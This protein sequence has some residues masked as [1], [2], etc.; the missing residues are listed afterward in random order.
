MVVRWYPK[1]FSRQV[2]VPVEVDILSLARFIF[3]FTSAE[4]FVVV[5]SFALSETS[6]HDVE[7]ADVA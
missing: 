5:E 3:G 2:W 4:E 1:T 6:Q 7:G